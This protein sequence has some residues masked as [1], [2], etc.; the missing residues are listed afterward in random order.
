MSAYA[1]P[2]E[3]RVFLP[4]VGFAPARGEPAARPTGD[5]SA[6]LV[7]RRAGIGRRSRDR[8]CE[9][10]QFALGLDRGAL[11]GARSGRPTPGRTDRARAPLALQPVSSGLHL[12]PCRDTH[13]SLPACVPRCWSRERR[14]PVA[15]LV[16]LCSV[17]QRKDLSDS[18][19]VVVV[20]TLERA[21]LLW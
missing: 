2:P 7:Q 19:V 6:R 14:R 15:A 12:S 21:Q 5:A 9:R 3:V 18:E 11:V 16:P 1:L 4:N 10:L 20:K 13:P 8:P 17:P